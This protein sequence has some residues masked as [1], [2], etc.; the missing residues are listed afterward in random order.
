MAKELILSGRVQGV[1]CRNYCS[2]YGAKMGI[3]GAASNLYDG[4]VQV[5]L[6]C[7]DI[8]AAQYVKAIKE[9]PFR[10]RFYG[11][12]EDVRIGDYSGA[13]SGDYNF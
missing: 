9:N 4:T 7:D 12:I 2:Q 13:I 11:K 1:L 3:K 5:L 6:D 10:M 8:K